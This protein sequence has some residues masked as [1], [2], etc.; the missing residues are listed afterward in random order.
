MIS[1]YSIEK[2]HILL[3][4][5]DSSLAKWIY[6]YL[7]PH[8]YKITV[9]YRGDHAIQLIKSKNP[10]LVLLDITLPIKDGFDICREVR[11]YYKRPILMMSARTNETDEVLA[12]ELGAD[13]FVTKPV[14]PR[15]LL[16]R[17]KTL[18]SR[19]ENEQLPYDTTILTFGNFS[20]DS[21]SRRAT[22]NNIPIDI[23]SNEFNLLWLLATH[24]GEIVTR[25]TLTSQIRGLHYDG[26]N[27]SMDVLISRIRKKIDDSSS[28]P[29]KIKTIWGKGYFFVPDAW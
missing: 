24:S 5:D 27:R 19:E 17:I 28:S 7:K 10:H 12:L 16:T 26:H 6:D 29:R 14:R 9:V 1:N 3:V 8:N 15:A 21:S 23:T 2:K 22:L 13:H 4:E 11:Q 20:I 25:E 18:L